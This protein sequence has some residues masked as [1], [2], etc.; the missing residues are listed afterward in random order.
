VVQVESGQLL[1]SITVSRTD[2]P[3]ELARRLV[4]HDPET[5]ERAFQ[6]TSTE[7]RDLARLILVDNDVRCAA[8]YFLSEHGWHD[9]ACVYVGSGVGAGIVTEGHVYYGANA[10]AGHIG[11]IDMVHSR[12]GWSL[13][14]KHRLEPIECQCGIVG[15]HFD[16]LAS[17]SGIQRIASALAPTDVA[18]T[19]AAVRETCLHTGIDADEY[20]REVFPRLLTTAHRRDAAHIPADVLDLLDSDPNL[21]QYF[22]K[23]REA[24]AEVLAAGL[25]TLA[26][27]VDPGTLVLCGPLIDILRSDELD[28]LIRSSL[29]EQMFYLRPNIVVE[30]DSRVALWRGAALLP[31][32]RG[33]PAVV[34]SESHRVD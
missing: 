4:Q 5:V 23:V 33:L 21:D 22:R 2:V 17:F 12:A 24:H 26:E 25:A 31:C 28:R 8:R 20:E 30:G 6:V 29:R 16:P 14:E 34:D 10:S 11:H 13:D 27:I 32:E 3:G 7:P 9:F 18:A 19:L 15:F 1:L